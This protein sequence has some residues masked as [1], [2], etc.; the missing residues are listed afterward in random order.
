MQPAKIDIILKYFG[1]ILR[2]IQQI[3]GKK[4]KLLI[5]SAEQYRNLK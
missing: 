3:K 5:A 4:Y 2:P 1:I